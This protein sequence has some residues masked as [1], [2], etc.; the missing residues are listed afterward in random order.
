MFKP[1]IVNKPFPEF[2]SV[3]GANDAVAA[4]GNPTISK[5]AVSEI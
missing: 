4:A 3:L 5:A 1:V 2:D